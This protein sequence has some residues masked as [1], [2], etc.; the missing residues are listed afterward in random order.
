MAARGALNSQCRKRQARDAIPFFGAD[1]KQEQRF[2]SIHPHTPL[3]VLPDVWREVEGGG[4]GG[5][6][7]KGEGS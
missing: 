5:A 3:T 4:G 7:A 6:G 1:I 2:N